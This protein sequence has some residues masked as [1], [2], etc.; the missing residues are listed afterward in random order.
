M[1]AKYI[2]DGSARRKIKQHMVLRSA[3]QSSQQVSSDTS[4]KKNMP[5]TGAFVQHQS[6]SMIRKR[7]MGKRKINSQDPVN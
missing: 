3:T 2:H 7:R 4:E 1:G 6:D 5:N